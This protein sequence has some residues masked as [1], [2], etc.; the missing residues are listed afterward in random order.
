M[1]TH[2]SKAAEDRTSDSSADVFL[3]W[4]QCYST[5]HLLAS[6]PYLESVHLNRSDN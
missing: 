3:I 5:K 1:E 6:T 2:N 4:M